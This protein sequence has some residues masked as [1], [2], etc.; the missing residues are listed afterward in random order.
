MPTSTSAITPYQQ[1]KE[2][3]L[4]PEQQS[5]FEV[6]L[7]QG[8]RTFI[9]SA[10]N[11]VNNNQALRNCDPQ[12]LF[13]EVMKAAVLQLP[14]DPNLGRAWIIPYKG[15]PQFQIGYKGLIDLARRTG[16]YE[17]LNVTQVYKGMDV[18]TDIL[19][20]EIK[21]TGGS[22][23]TGE[24]I[25]YAAYFKLKSGMTKA[26]YWTKE[27]VLAH[28]KKY[29]KSFGNS[30]SAWSTDFDKMAMKTVLKHLISAW[31]PMSLEMK[32][33]MDNDEQLEELSEFTDNDSVDVID[34]TAVEI[35]TP[36]SEE[37]QQPE[38]TKQP[39]PPTTETQQETAQPAD[40]R[41]YAP[42]YLKKRLNEMAIKNSEIGAKCS[43]NKMSLILV[44]VDAIF[45]DP[46]GEKRRAAWKYWF[47]V[48]MQKATD[49]Q[50]LAVDKWAHLTPTAFT[51]Q[52]AQATYTAATVGE[53]Q[54][55]LL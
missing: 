47:G 36:S 39:T 9:A 27:K 43:E 20:G 53:G 5:M 16:Q 25:G 23:V 55:A 46:S 54:G 4:A 35:A 3:M 17:I 49:A 28:A 12:L 38:V 19:T 50:I 11:T 32:E 45:D 31:G 22:N 26:V 15:V 42:E 13:K 52:E 33:V 2:L 24:V 34:S 37:T 29:S 10:L 40:Q 1:F 6:A 7:Q 51:Y 44:D 30:N 48:N 14:I 18:Q 21:I 8:A 41:P